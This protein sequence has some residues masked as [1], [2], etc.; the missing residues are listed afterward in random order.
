MVVVM[1]VIMVVVVAMVTVVMVP[2]E[3]GH[4]WRKGISEGRSRKDTNEI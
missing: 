3:E 4:P 2:V 1:M